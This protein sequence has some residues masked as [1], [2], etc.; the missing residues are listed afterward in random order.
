MRQ[1]LA[2]MKFDNAPGALAPGLSVLAQITTKKT[3]IT[4]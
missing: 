2:R 3:I 1:L 4:A